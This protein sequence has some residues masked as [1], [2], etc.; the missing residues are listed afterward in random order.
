MERKEAV[1]LLSKYP[2]LWDILKEF[3]Q[4]S[5]D[6]KM[7]AAYKKRFSP[8]LAQIV[9][10]KEGTYERRRLIDYFAFPTQKIRSVEIRHGFNEILGSTPYRKGYFSSQG[11]TSEGDTFYLVSPSGKIYICPCDEDFSSSL[12]DEPDLKKGLIL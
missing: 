5:C 7:V 4:I 3:K 12:W 10:E 11:K 6:Q 1:K 8:P 9:G 2:F